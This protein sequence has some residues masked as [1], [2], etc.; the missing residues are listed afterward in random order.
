MYTCRICLQDESN[1]D[2][3]IAPCKC[4]GTQKYIHIYCMNQLTSNKKYKTKCPTCQ[5]VYTNDVY[6]Y[7]SLFNEMKKLLYYLFA[8]TY[9][10][11]FALALQEKY[12]HPNKT[13][14][15]YLYIMICLLLLYVI[16][17]YR[18]QFIYKETQK[19]GYYQPQY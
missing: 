4:N 15:K 10:I 3:V 11:F 6:M 7:K 19:I 2:N 16:F 9:I 8:F 5:F 13:K 18:I 12:K 14:F 17:C 1:R